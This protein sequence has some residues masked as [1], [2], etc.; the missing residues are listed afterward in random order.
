M[1]RL[2]EMLDPLI[3]K[4]A[5]PFQEFDSRLPEGFGT[6]GGGADSP[7]KLPDRITR[8]AANATSVDLLRFFTH[9]E[10]SFLQLIHYPP[11]ALPPAPACSSRSAGRCDAAASLLRRQA[12]R[13]S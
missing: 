2:P 12:H 9:A 8:F 4:S 7:E 10:P 13:L 1:G 6:P 5:D 11:C 3:Q